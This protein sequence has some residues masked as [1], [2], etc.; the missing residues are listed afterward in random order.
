MKKEP[1]RIFAR[2]DVEIT[3]KGERTRQRIIEKAAP[4]FNQRGYSGASMQEIMEAAGIEK[5]GIYRHF[6]S[7]EELASEAFKYALGQAVKA[8]MEGQDEIRGAIP[9]LQF[10][11][12]CFVEKPSPVPG[13]CPLLNTATDAD[14]GNAALR[15]LASEGLLNWKRRIGNVVKEGLRVQ[16]IAP[17]TDP[18][19][20]ANTII[21]ALEGALMISRLEGSRDA[22]RD[23][24]T[25]LEAFINGLAA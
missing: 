17:R 13:G 16:E 22:L 11:V 12:R 6:S 7:K 20:V 24:W 9:K 3:R 1:I 5:G 15:S 25:N 4:I 10:M 23:A 21:G 14:D 18:G 19:R 2:V 8:R